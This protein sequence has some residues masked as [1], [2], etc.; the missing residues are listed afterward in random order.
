MVRTEVVRMGW[1]L[2]LLCNRP[3]WRTDHRQS[4]SFRMVVSVLLPNGNRTGR[5]VA[6]ASPWRP[7]VRNDADG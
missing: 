1:D 5:V 3:K 2:Q 6:A 4:E 7:M